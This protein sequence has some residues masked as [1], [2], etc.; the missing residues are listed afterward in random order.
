M[1]FAFLR[2][3]PFLLSLPVR[4]CFIQRR[5]FDGKRVERRGGG[6]FIQCLIVDRKR[7]QRLEEYFFF[8]SVTEVI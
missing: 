2:L 3:V 4:L 6:I 7:V 1:R 8:F 5:M